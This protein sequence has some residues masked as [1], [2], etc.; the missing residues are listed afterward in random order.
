[1]PT[2]M[3][4]DKRVVVTSG[5][6]LIGSHLAQQVARQNYHV[7]MLDDLSAGKKKNIAPLMSSTTPQTGRAEFVQGSVT[8]LLVPQ[9]L[10]HGVDYVFHLAATPSVPRSVG[11]AFI[12]MRQISP[13]RR[14]YLLLPDSQSPQ[15]VTKLAGEY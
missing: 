14:T 5:A 1:M 7:V 4:Q 13:E 6:G 9:E 11:N 15:A 3:S 12:L 2:G 8:H 10:F